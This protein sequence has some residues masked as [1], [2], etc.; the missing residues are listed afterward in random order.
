MPLL[1]KQW[2][3]EER[4]AIFRG[5]L[6]PASGPVLLRGAFSHPPPGEQAANRLVAPGAQA[7]GKAELVCLRATIGSELFPKPNVDNLGITNYFELS[8]AFLPSIEDTMKHVA[9]SRSNSVQLITA[10]SLQSTSLFFSF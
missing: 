3:E 5:K 7:A 10:F 4:A 1:L 8:N 9:I 6:F 2:G